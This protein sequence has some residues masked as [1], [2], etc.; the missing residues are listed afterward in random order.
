MHQGDFA[1]GLL[2][3]SAETADRSS[4]SDAQG[5]MFSILLLFQKDFML[6]ESRTIIMYNMWKQMPGGSCSE[7]CGVNGHL[8][9]KSRGFWYHCGAVQIP[10][11]SIYDSE[12][13]KNH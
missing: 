11:W 6:K 5:L 12:F 8:F 13:L 9:P 3:S 2:H 4:A 1:G 10:G 7:G